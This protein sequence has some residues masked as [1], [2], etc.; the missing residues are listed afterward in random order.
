MAAAGSRSKNAGRSTRIRAGMSALGIILQIRQIHRHGH[1]HAARMRAE[2][3]EPPLWIGVARKLNLKHDIVLPAFRPRPALRYRSASSGSSA[4]NSSGCSSSP[5]STFRAPSMKT[6]TTMRVLPFLSIT[7]TVTYA[8]AV[9][10]VKIVS[11]IQPL[12]SEVNDPPC[13]RGSRA[14]C[15]LIDAFALSSATACGGFSTFSRGLSSA[16]WGRIRDARRRSRRHVSLPTRCPCCST[17]KAAARSRPASGSGTTPTR[18]SAML[19]TSGIRLSRRRLVRRALLQPRE[20]IGELRGEPRSRNTSH[21]ARPPHYV[22]PSTQDTERGDPAPTA[23]VSWRYARAARRLRQQPPAMGARHCH[24]HTS[25]GAEEPAEDRLSAAL[26]RNGLRPAKDTF[27]L[28]R[29]ERK[30]CP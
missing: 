20:Y 16:A 25:A 24:D 13:N 5:S 8:R 30:C 2:T 3:I 9:A 1:D 14:A 29:P 17:A 18:S 26:N 11:G 10:G 22:R 19:V 27:H 28:G 4:S 21:C 7:I 15:P 12:M 6:R 23:R